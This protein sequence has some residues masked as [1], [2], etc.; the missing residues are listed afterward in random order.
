MLLAHSENALRVK[1]C[2]DGCS[3]VALILLSDQIRREAPSTLAYFSRQGVELK[4]ISGDNP[5]TVSQVAKKAG[6]LDW[7]SYVDAST[8]DNVGAV[9]DRY[10]IFGR[11]TPQQKLELIQA[12][13]S[14]VHVVGM[15][16]DGAN[17]V[18]A[19]KEADV[20]VAMQSGSMPPERFRTCAFRQQFCFHA[21][22]CGEGRRSINNVERSAALFLTKTVYSSY[23]P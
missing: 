8:L 15:T 10:R 2:P 14:K 4:I 1:R 6:F 20:S 12:L 13:R 9:C 7:E 5:I 22:G 19:L 16:G 17:D 18:L 3:P 23:L 11:V 21:K